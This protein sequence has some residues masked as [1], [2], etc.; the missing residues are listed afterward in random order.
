[1]ANFNF[2]GLV[3][4]RKNR[5]SQDLIVEMRIRTKS[6]HL[7]TVRYAKRAIQIQDFGYC[8][9]TDYQYPGRST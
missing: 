5:R 9:T 6:I 1:M 7:A 4:N 8:A 2:T 3:P